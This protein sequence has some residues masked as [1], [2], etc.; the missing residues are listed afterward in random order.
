MENKT[1]KYDLTTS[2][3]TPIEYYKILILQRYNDLVEA[4]ESYFKN[5]HTGVEVSINIIHARTTSLYLA[6][7]TYL[8]RKSDKFDK[9]D[10]ILFESEPTE[11]QLLNIFK[12]INE[13]L[14][15]DRLTRFDTK[16][17]YDGTRV[18]LENEASGL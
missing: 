7:I 5:K 12:L 11:K 9:T 8:K 16:Q 18:E 14:D 10:S 15:I 3:S 6:L 4:W 1:Y 2:V 13:Q 17:T